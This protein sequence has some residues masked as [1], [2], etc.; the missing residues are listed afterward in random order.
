MGKR[1][2]RFRGAVEVRTRLRLELERPCVVTVHVEK[3]TP[4]NIRTTVDAIGLPARLLGCVGGVEETVAEQ[5]LDY[6]N[7]LISSPRFQAAMHID[8]PAMLER[9]WEA[10]LVVD[11]PATDEEARRP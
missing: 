2:A 6:V 4:D 3:A 9:A 8:V 11:V 5:V 7:D 10:D 1:T